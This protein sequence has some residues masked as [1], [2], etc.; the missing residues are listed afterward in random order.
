L[1]VSREEKRRKG[2]DLLFVQLPVKPD[3]RTESAEMFQIAMA[4][5]ECAEL[6]AS[7]SSPEINRGVIRVGLVDCHPQMTIRVWNSRIT[8]LLAG[9]TTLVIVQT[10]TIIQNDQS[11]FDDGR[12]HVLVPI[13]G[14]EMENE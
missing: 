4:A 1:V 9:G 13:N 11:I 7:K 3:R 12:F 10:T 5:F 2:K 6:F 14:G 8:N